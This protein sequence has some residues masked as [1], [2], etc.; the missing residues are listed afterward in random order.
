MI[1]WLRWVDWPICALLG[2]LLLGALFTDQGGAA[3]LSLCTV[4]LGLFLLRPSWWSSLLCIPLA[5]LFLVFSYT[6]CDIGQGPVTDLVHPAHQI[7]PLLILYTIIRFLYV[8]VISIA[9]SEAEDSP[10]SS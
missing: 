8:L 4:P 2:L 3:L 1:R 7:A 6:I 9:K 10:K 5:F